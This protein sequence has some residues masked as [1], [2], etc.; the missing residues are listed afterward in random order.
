MAKAINTAM[1]KMMAGRKFIKPAAEPFTRA[2][3]KG[4]APRESVMAFRLQARVKIRMAGTIALK[5]SGR[6]AMHSSKDRTRRI[7]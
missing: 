4:C 6:Q 5:P 1:T 2:S 3:T 7:R